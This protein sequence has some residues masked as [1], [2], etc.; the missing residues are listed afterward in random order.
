MKLYR[1]RNSFAVTKSNIWVDKH[2]KSDMSDAREKNSVFFRYSCQITLA[3]NYA[4]L[5]L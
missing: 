5:C 3:E 1:Y 2:T 4:L